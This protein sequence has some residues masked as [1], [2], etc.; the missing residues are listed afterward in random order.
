MVRNIVGALLH[1][2]RGSA[3]AHWMAEVL[4]GRDRTRAARTA[5]A[6]G[7]YLYG[8]SYE[9][10]WGLP[11]GRARGADLLQAILEAPEAP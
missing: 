6:A 11:T 2:G 5:D 8:V 9:P 4:E 10:Q 1:I 3:P 7:L